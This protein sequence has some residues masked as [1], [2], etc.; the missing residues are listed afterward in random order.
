MERREGRVEVFRS[1]AMRDDRERSKRQGRG[2]DKQERER[3]G[4]EVK[5]DKDVHS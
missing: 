5:E 3:E 2:A 4:L 1:G